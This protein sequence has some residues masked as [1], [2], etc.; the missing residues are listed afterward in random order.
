MPLSVE[1]LL[2]S[3]DDPFVFF[4]LQSV[5]RSLNALVSENDESMMA[6]MGPSGVARKYWDVPTELMHEEIGLLLGAAFVLGQATLTQTVA[7]LKRIR[8][9][10]GA[11]S[12][13][14][15]KKS[16]MLTLGSLDDAREGTVSVAVIDLAANYF[17]HHQ[18][19][20]DDWVTTEG[21]GNL[22]TRTIQG[23]R[24]LGMRPGAFLLTDN[25]Y[26]ALGALG[27]Y[28]P[29]VSN[30]EQ[31]IR[32]WRGRLARGL[33]ASLDLADPNLEVRV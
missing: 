18:E 29:D 3:L 31:T 15:E 5:C 16:E 7:L 1:H 12:E 28:P 10:V 23:C 24:D 27:H 9:E 13:I 21:K 33:Y 8:L 25:L 22:Q 14:P 4:P 32:S 17:K 30:I 6:R 11:T 26:S 2:E 20:P 19:W